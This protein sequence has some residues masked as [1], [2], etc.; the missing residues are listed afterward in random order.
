MF[1]FAVSGLVWKWRDT[2]P[3]SVTGWLWYLGTLV[4]VIGIIA[5][6]D[7]LGMADRYAYIPLIGVFVMVIWGLAA[8]AES[9]KVG[10]PTRAVVIAIVLA[11]LTLLTRHQIGYW[12]NPRMISSGMRFAPRK[13]RGTHSPATFAKMI[14][15]TWIDNLKTT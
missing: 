3:Y 6:G 2:S 14:S 1:L 13:R 10:R 4:P 7:D 9:L 11:V 12:R 8:W 15:Q 5:V